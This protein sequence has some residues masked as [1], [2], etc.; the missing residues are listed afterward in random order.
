MLHCGQKPT[1]I[2]SR[3]PRIGLLTTTIQISIRNEPLHHTVYYCSAL[4][5]QN[6]NRIFLRINFETNTF[7]LLFRTSYTNPIT[8]SI[9]MYLLCIII[10]YY[11]RLLLL[12]VY[13]HITCAQ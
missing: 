4:F 6:H 12:L 3:I 8:I 13:A 2:V 5:S 7:Q 1:S 11:P 9:N 10:F